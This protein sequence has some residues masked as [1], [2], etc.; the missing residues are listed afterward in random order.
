M[1]HRR[2]VWRDLGVDLLE[3]LRR[4]GVSPSLQRPGDAAKP[5]VSLWDAGSEEDL[6]AVAAAARLLCGRIL[7]CGSAGLAAALAGGSAGAAARAPS[8]LLALI[9]SRHRVSLEQL[10]RIRP[11][12]VRLRSV[13]AEVGEIAERLESGSLAVTPVLGPGLSRE[14]AARR[15]AALFVELLMALPAP[16][17]LLVSGGETLRGVCLGLR[18]RSLEVAGEILP[19]IPLSVFQGGPFEGVQVISKS[20]AFGG[21]DLLKDLL[22]NDRY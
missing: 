18:V 11:L 5:G 22:T 1:R 16:L 7:W 20:G 9:G 15:I 14:E 4:L 12:S 10:A 19:G 2:G 13:K 17:P 3:D 6:L 8:P 21:P